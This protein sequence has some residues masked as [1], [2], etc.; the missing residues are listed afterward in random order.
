MAGKPAGQ[1]LRLA[2]RIT[3]RSPEIKRTIDRHYAPQP[4]RRNARPRVDGGETGGGNYP[5]KSTGWVREAWLV[6]RVGGWRPRLHRWVPTHPDPP[7]SPK[8]RSRRSAW[9]S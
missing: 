2:T 5:P 3:T 6:K 8:L 4:A 9:R 7:A 1:R